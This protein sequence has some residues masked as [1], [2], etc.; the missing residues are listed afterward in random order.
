MKWAEGDLL[1]FF[2]LFQ[3]P[4]FVVFCMLTGG[5]EDTRGGLISGVLE[6]GGRY[7]TT[8]RP[9]RPERTKN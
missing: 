9:V 4:N 6:S 2:F 3:L 8:D 7:R 1:F 5:V